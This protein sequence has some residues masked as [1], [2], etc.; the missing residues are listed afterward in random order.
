M[1][2]LGFDVDAKNTHFPASAAAEF[3]EMWPALSWR[4]A[5]NEAAMAYTAHQHSDKT[6][7]V[8][9]TAKEFSDCSIFKGSRIRELTLNGTAVTSLA[10]LAGLPLKSLTLRRTP[11]TD[12]S[13]LAVI[14]LK[15]LSVREMDVT[16][17]SVLRRTPLC[18]SLESLSL[19]KSKVIDFSPVAACKSVKRFT[20]AGTPLADIAPLRG[21][22]LEEL[23]LAGSKVRDLSALAGM[24]LTG[25][26]LDGLD[27]TDVTPLLK[28]PTLKEIILPKTAHD[29]EALCKLPKLQRI[30]YKYD[31]KVPGPSMTVAEFLADLPARQAGD[32]L[33]RGRYAEAEPGLAETLAA[34]R[35]RLSPGDTGTVPAILNLANCRA[36]GGHYQEAIPLFREIIEIRSKSRGAVPDT[37]EILDWYALAL[38]Q[39]AAG[40]RD[41]YRA[42]CAEMLRRCAGSISDNTAERAL[43]Y[44][45][46]APGGG[47]SNAQVR[48]LI[49][50]SR[51]MEK[52][53]LAYWFRIGLGLAEYRAGNFAA[54]ADALQKVERL[55]NSSASSL[56]DLT[57][58]MISHRTG[59]KDDAA[60]RLERSRTAVAGHW[61]LRQENTSDVRGWHNWLAAQLL[62][63][64]AEAVLAAPPAKP[65]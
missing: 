4:R 44:C 61:P 1:Q 33:A 30:S 41:G 49:E 43:Q 20:G 26:F 37:G 31:E 38:M 62:L 19:E 28:C 34:T 60:M 27:I 9:V 47:A 8:T 2:W 58:A 36:W 22:P 25:V 45:S 63:L 13:P 14:A 7:E 39:A 3:W 5:L 18:D 21:L 6:W 11:V 48:A 50:T 29:V 15:T 65:P 55:E 42:V 59:N 35:K 51:P 24:P 46:V 56:A 52:T 16:D 10:P 23:Y 53:S 64:E 32:P 40:D 12:L 17:V 54:A 57:L